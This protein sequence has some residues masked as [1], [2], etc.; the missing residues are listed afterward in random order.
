[1]TPI[2][3]D[4][5]AAHRSVH[6]LALLA[7]HRG[8]GPEPEPL[9]EAC[10]LCGVPVAYGARHVCTAYR[11]AQRVREHKREKREEELL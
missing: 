10:G 1:M 7:F 8:E 2:S 9:V 3:L 11:E 5:A 4:N 6:A